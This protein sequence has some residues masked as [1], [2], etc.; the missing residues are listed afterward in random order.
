MKE[1]K[2]I[3]S[4]NELIKFVLNE[5]SVKYLFF[6]GH[7]SNSPQTINKTCFS[8][9]FNSPFEIDGVTYSTAEH[10]MM[11]EK[12]RLFEGESQ[13]NSQLIQQI[14]EASHPNDAK[15]LGRQVE[16]FNNELWCQHR[17]DIVVNGNMAKFSQNSKL[18]EFLLATKNR[19]L[20]EASP[21]DKIW[22]IGLAEDHGDVSNP[23]KWKGLNLL[24]FALMEV[25]ERLSRHDS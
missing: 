16:E 23:S 22:G 21:V 13:L 25:R 6:W 5:E 10:Y 2:D 4:K 19:V 7:T 3:R 24:G 17:F 20:V 12:A 11:A 1:I 15:K 18:A 14:I 8:Q 9:W